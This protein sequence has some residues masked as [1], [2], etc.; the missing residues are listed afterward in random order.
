M[1]E[2]NAL[3]KRPCPDCGGE[4]EWNAGKQVFA[5]PFCGFISKE[6]PGGPDATGEIREHDLEATIN[7][8]GDERRGYG[9]QSVHVK[10]TSCQAISVFEPG[11]VAQRC[12]FCGS[13]SLVA[14]EETRDPITPESLLPVKLSEAQVRDLLKQWYASRWFAPDALRR[15]ALTDTLQGIYLPYW[16]FDARAYSQWTA[17]S[18]DHYWD[19]ELFSDANGNRQTRQVQKTRW[20]PSSGELNHFFDD[21]LVPGTVGV[22][23]DLLRSV[24]PFPT[25]QL[26][27]YDA[28]YVRGWV[29]ERYQVDLRRASDTSRA[30]MDQAMYSMCGQQVPGDTYR[31]L[32][33]DTRYDA[34]TFKHILVPVWLVTYTLG[35][36]TFQTIVNGYTGRIAGDRPISWMKIFCY[37]ILP[38]LV[39]LGLFLLSRR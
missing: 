36:R 12:A 38:I 18:G 5:C 9:T 19:T 25:D 30:A 26:K 10:C 29:V 7:A 37:V 6:Q 15:R 2:L 23:I 27:A 17:E 24:E 4:M 8:V 35:A 32:N 11:R 28:A 21:D 33:V 3:G 13:P 14:Y 34:R 20:Y 1:A 16:T 39:I 31:N 22:R